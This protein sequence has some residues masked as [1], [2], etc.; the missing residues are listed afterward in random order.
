[1]RLELAAGRRD[2]FGAMGNWWLSHMQDVVFIPGNW[3]GPGV[4]IAAGAG[5]KP[6][7]KTKASK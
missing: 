1:M 2:C 6:K 7:G 5:A 4:R 3:K